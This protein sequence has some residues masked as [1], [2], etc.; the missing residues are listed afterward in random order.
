MPYAL[1]HVG[2][3]YLFQ[4]RLFDFDVGDYWIVFQNLNG[5]RFQVTTKNPGLAA[6]ELFL[7]DG[8]KRER[9]LRRHFIRERDGEEVGGAFELFKRFDQH[10]FAFF[11]DRYGVRDPL[12]LGDLVR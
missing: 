10:Q 8:V 3:K 9:V 11:E 1:T 6:G 4:R 2:N 5:V 7:D 12:D